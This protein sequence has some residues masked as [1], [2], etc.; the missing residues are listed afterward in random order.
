MPNVS[1]PLF[2]APITSPEMSGVVGTP[3]LVLNKLLNSHPR[4]STPA[5]PWREEDTGTC[6]RPLMT[7]VWVK[8]KSE[9]PWP[10]FG[11][12]QNN[13]VMEFEKESPK[14]AAELSS[15]DLLY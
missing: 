4:S 13:V 5:S 8:L 14:R 2:C 7:A 15:I 1:E 11:S 9:G 12:Y 3:L 6:Q 10:A